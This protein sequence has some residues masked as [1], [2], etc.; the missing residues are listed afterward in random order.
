MTRGVFE[1]ARYICRKVVKQ[2][3]RFNVT[4][5][6]A[7]VHLRHGFGA[8]PRTTPPL[9]VRQCVIY[10]R[11]AALN[12]S[13]KDRV[14]TTAGSRRR[15]MPCLVQ[16]STRSA[17]IAST[18]RTARPAGALR[19]SH[20]NILCVGRPPTQHNASSQRLPCR[21]TR[22]D[23]ITRRLSVLHQASSHSATSAQLST[24]PFCV[25]QSNPTHQ[26]TDP[27]RPNPTNKFNCL[28][29]P[30]LV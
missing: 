9:R 28:L 11:N 20:V 8:R 30:N 10:Q 24:G 18:T 19:Q 26:L 27:T 12:K 22:L 13:L 5:S 21:T 3:I 1:L 23:C 17:C 15:V 2:L 16:S 4:A 6:V 7:R 25:T 29:Q 14:A